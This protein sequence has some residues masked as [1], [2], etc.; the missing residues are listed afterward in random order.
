M[1]N[2]VPARGTGFFGKLVQ[3]RLRREIIRIRTG[4]VG[5]VPTAA[6]PMERLLICRTWWRKC[7][8]RA[9]QARR[10]VRSRKN[11]ERRTSNVER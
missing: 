11:F 6:I 10:E 5:P 4:P 1:K 9:A 7:Q 3:R 8:R 2:P